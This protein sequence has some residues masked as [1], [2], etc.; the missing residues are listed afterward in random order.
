MAKRSRIVSQETREKISE[1]LKGRK[2][3]EETRKKMSESQKRAWDRVPKQGELKF[4]C[5]E[6]K[7]A[8]EMIYAYLSSST[9]YLDNWE[10]DKEV[11]AKSL[12]QILDNI[13]VSFANIFNNTIDKIK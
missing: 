11:T 1:K 8:W 7:I 10:S 3:S 4:D 5:K 13:N 9:N 12:R 6:T 2:I